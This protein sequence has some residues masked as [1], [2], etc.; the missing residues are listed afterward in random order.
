[1]SLLQKQGKNGE[2]ANHVQMF[3]YKIPKQNH[4]AMFR[5]QQKLTRILRKNGTLYSEFY[6]LSYN[7]PFQGFTNLART[8]SANIEEEEVWVEI[9]H[10]KDLDHRNKVVAVAGEDP[11]A[12][13]L[14]EEMVNLVS[15]SN[16]LV[17]GELKCLEV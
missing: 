6:Q 10:Y 7:E 9:D 13:P 5:L 8:L 16:S 15:K 17:M 4:D 11:E 1:M 12:Q 3:L 14:F 2:D